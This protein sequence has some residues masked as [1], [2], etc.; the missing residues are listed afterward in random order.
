MLTGLYIPKIWLQNL[1]GTERMVEYRG[2]GIGEND[3]N[4]PNKKKC[5]NV[6][7]R[8][9]YLMCLNSSSLRLLSWICSWENN[10]RNI[11][12][13]EK[14]N[15]E[16]LYMGSARQIRYVWCLGRGKTWMRGRGTEKI[17]CMSFLMISVHTYAFEC[18]NLFIFFLIS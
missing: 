8:K 12:P 16:I 1:V 13:G 17:L 6:R 10:F 3:Q 5:Q 9:K 11:D 7:W 15:R 2:Y 14:L 4:I 18:F